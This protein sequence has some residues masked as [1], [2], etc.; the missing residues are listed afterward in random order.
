MS[1]ALALLETLHD[2]S[3][4]LRPAGLPTP[5]R[6][7]ASEALWSVRNLRGRMVEL[8]CPY[9]SGALTFSRELILDA[10]AEGETCIWIAGDSGIFYPPDLAESGVD[11]ASLVIVRCPDSESQY[12]ALDIVLR[13]GGFGLALVD[14]GAAEPPSLSALSRLAGLVH[15]H[16][17]TL[18]FLTRKA[19]ET[20]SL[21]SLI[22]LRVEADRHREGI[23]CFQTFL[24]A[25]KDKQRGPGW[26]HEVVVYGPPGLC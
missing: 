1:S 17:T 19:S 9:S 23:S 12:R 2:L 26:R 13:S 4:P 7:P 15:R 8:S 6:S 25:T 24:T 16:E 3:C 14:I 11:L 21:G 5:D 20:P 10:Q 22:S 18:V